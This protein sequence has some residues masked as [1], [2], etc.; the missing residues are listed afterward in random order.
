[1]SDARPIPAGIRTTLNVIA[2]IHAELDASRTNAG[3]SSSQHTGPQVA[4]DRKQP[5]TAA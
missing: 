4:H 2:G 3:S 1:M 5:K